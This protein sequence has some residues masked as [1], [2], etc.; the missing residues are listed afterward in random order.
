MMWS[1]VGVSVDFVYLILKGGRMNDVRMNVGVCCCW[2]IHHHRLRATRHHHRRATPD[3]HYVR[4]HLLRFFLK[5]YNLGFIDF[6][7]K[8]DDCPEVLRARRV[9]Q[10]DVVRPKDLPR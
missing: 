6:L 7:G 8:V 1:S 5:V 4:V 9:R 3:R 10:V 2:T